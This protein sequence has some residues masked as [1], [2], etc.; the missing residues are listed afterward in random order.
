MAVPTR[1]PQGVSTAASWQFFSAMGLPNPFYYHQFADDFDVVPAT[2]NGYTVTG[3]GTVAAGSTDGGNVVLTTTAVAVEFEEIQRTNATFAPVAGKKTYFVTRVALSDVTNSALIAG[4]SAA[5]TTPFTAPPTNYIWVTKASGST[6]F[7]LVINNNGT[8]TTTAFP[9]TLATAI[10]LANGVVFDIGVHVTIKGALTATIVP[11]A[12][13]YAP[14][15]GT[16]M[17]GSTLRQPTIASTVNVGTTLAA[18]PLAP[19]VAVQAGTT[20]IKTA[21]VDFLGAFRER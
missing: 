5:T 10:G 7:N 15:S 11:N 20:T 2:A 19:I 16:G 14:M 1:F 21:T 6:N 17:A 18:T 3:T 12:V 4:L 9:T 8:T 13:G